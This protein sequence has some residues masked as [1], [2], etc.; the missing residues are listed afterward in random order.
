MAKI[1]LSGTMVRY[2][3]G[4]LNL[5][6]LAW[7]KGIKKLGHEIAFVEKSMWE[8]ACFDISKN[9]MTNDCTYGLS[10]IQSVFEQYGLANSWCFVDLDRNY[11][12]MS[13]KQVENTFRIADLFIDFEWGEWREEAANVPLKVFVDGEPGWFQ[14]KLN[15][16]IGNGESLPDYDYYFTSG[17][18]IGTEKCHVPTVGIKWL[19]TLPPAL[20]SGHV[21]SKSPHENAFTTIMNWK[22]NK[23]IH[24][25]GKTYGQKDREFNKF[26]QLPSLVKESMEVAV[27]GPAV[28]RENLCK[29]GWQVK[30]ADKISKSI[31]SYLNY[32]RESKG[33][34][35]IAK[36]VFVETRCGWF[37]DRSVYYMS[38]GKP[39]VV[40]ET[41]W[42]DYLPSGQGIF[43]FSNMEEAISAISAIN[44][45]YEKHSRCARE[46]AFD[47]FEAD[48]V[49]KKFL[50]KIGL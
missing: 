27:S 17:P 31:D 9:I 48:Q 11:H 22:S 12:G 4:G 37:G 19:H 30:N 44:E 14:I 13:K 2:P 20:I 7:L 28:P 5:W 33:E 38:F 39:T 1:V 29:Q 43:S 46:I 49:M 25:Q 36:N 42:T 6:H 24:Y 21:P 32:I 47:Y 26:I 35:S 34:Y 8:Q 10:V 41:G 18:L 3:V 16:L 15:N 23:E 45:D 40:Q 50:T